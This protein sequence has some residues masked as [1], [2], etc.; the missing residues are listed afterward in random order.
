MEMS[1]VDNSIK[2][3]DYTL[4]K[5]NYLQYTLYDSIMLLSIPLGYW[6]NKT[7][8]INPY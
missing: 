1:K 2:I 6:Y 7:H 5:N 3:N 8:S 4:E